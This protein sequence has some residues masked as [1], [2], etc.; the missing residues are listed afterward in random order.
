MADEKDDELDELLNSYNSEF[1][2][3]PNDNQ[4]DE[5]DKSDRTG[6]SETIRDGNNEG[7]ETPSNKGD[8]NSWQGNPAYYQSG[9]KQGKLKPSM[10]H[11]GPAKE[12]ME[13]SGSLID[14]ALFIM[15][16]DMLLPLLI[17]VANNQLSKDK[18]DIEDLQL[19][20]KQKKDLAPIS[21]EVVKKLSM[22]ANPVWL[23]IIAMGGIYGINFMVA[24]QASKK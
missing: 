22:E 12:K 10:K 1:D 23:L 18:I 8:S 17:T 14:G 19:T 9:K 20:E 3:K 21:D 2:E 6:D 16:I 13:I 15:L 24:K 5:S 7:N 11:R 4:L